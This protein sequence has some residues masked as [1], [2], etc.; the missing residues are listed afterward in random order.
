M[1][2]GLRL[3]VLDLR[4][5]TPGLLVP[6]RGREF[7]MCALINVLTAAPGTVTKLALSDMYLGD[8]CAAGWPGY[9]C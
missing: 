9:V 4:V 1:A 5:P 6:L 7:Q 8:Q 2:S 3:D